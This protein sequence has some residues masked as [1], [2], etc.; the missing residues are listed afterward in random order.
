M[1]KTNITPAPVFAAA[2]TLPVPAATAAGGYRITVTCP[3]PKTQP[4][5]QLTPNDGNHSLE[6][7]FLNE[8]GIPAMT[9][10]GGRS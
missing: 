6:Q 1:R 7:R 10:R 8:F 2:A 9:I 5:R 3:V 4:E